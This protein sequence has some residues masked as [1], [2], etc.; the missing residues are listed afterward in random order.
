MT[1]RVGFIG[2]FISFAAYCLF[3][4]AVIP[5]PAFAACNVVTSV[6]LAWYNLKKS[7]WASVALNAAYFLASL[8]GVFS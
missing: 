5:L 3:Q 8:V 2:A 4:C 7:A 1:E 6:L